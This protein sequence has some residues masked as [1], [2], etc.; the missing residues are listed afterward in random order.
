MRYAAI[1]YDW[2]T[3]IFSDGDHDWA[4]TGSRRAYFLLT[5]WKPT[6]RLL[7]RIS[8]CQRNSMISSFCCS[9]NVVT[10]FFFL[11]F[12]LVVLWQSLT[13]SIFAFGA[14]W[15]HPSKSFKI[16]TKFNDRNYR[17]LLFCCRSQNETLCSHPLDRNI[18]FYRCLRFFYPGLLSRPRLW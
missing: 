2:W 10:T 16:T 4:T 8:F 13:L 7:Y 5:S 9:L 14:L 17:C 3:E 6:S 1:S 18:P 12:T 15:W 11:S